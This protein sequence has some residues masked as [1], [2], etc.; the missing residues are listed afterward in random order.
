MKNNKRTDPFEKI[1]P[2]SYSVCCFKLNFLFP[3]LA[4]HRLPYLDSLK[5]N[6]LDL[7]V[8]FLARVE[9][10]NPEA[11]NFREAFCMLCGKPSFLDLPE[12]IS[13]LE[14]AGVSIEYGTEYLYFVWSGR[15]FYKPLFLDEEI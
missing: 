13:V 6:S 3:F 8:T 11:T 2:F 15:K 7:I 1:N 5:E 10:E 4:H 9:R 12:I 14:F